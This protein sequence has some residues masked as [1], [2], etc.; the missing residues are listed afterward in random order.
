MYTIKATLF[1]K[2]K[3]MSKKPIFFSKD[4]IPSCE[5]CEFGKKSI[6]DKM[7]LCPKKGIVSPYYSCRIFRYSP[8]KRLPRRTPKMPS[9]DNLDFTL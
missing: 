3:T 5:Y 9:F 7:V 6:D 2:E 4:I 8:L 1:K